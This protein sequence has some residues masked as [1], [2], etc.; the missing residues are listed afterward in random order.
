MS[1][2]EGRRRGSKLWYLVL[3]IPFVFT[4]WVPSYN[5][6]EPTFGGFPF[7][8]WYQMLWIL[9]TAVLTGIVYFLTE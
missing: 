4:L 1:Q 3:L 9:I 5:F 2:N 7:F 8:Y 6:A